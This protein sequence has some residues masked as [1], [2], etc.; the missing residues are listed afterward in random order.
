MVILFNNHPHLPKSY[1]PFL[2]LTHFLF[3]L[4]LR[5]RFN[6]D[7]TRFRFDDKLIV[8]LLYFVPLDLLKQFLESVLLSLLLDLLRFHHN[9]I[10]GGLEILPSRSYFV[11]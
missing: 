1:D 6:H 7:F 2:L 5:E 10:I 3:Q 4:S 9:G 11:K 8:E